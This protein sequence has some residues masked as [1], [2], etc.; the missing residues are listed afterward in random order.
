M[1]LQEQGS[2]AG[3]IDELF[4]ETVSLGQ[5]LEAGESLLD[6]MLPHRNS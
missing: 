2:T 4:P 1:A 6:I 5:I 3:D